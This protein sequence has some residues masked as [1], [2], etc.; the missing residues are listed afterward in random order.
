MRA[1]PENSPAYYHLAFV[2]A[3]CPDPK[4][5]D[6]KKA[7]EYATESCKRTSWKYH[8]QIGVLAAAYAEAGDFKEAIRWQEK[9]IELVEAPATKEIYRPRLKLYR[10]NQPVQV[11]SRYENK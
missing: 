1:N 7:V 9:A 2:L 11:R 10:Q 3:M 5:R 6:G 4:Y 8:Q